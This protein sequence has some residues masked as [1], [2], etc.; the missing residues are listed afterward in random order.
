MNARYKYRFYPTDKQVNQ[1]AHQFGCTRYVYNWAL[2]MKSEAFREHG[3]KIGYAKTSK[4]LTSL[5]QE[6]DKTWLQDVSNVP[7]QQALRHLDKA[8]TAFFR[9][10]TKYPRFKRK[11]H[12]QSAT[13]T[14]NAFS[15]KD[16]DVEGQPFVSLAKQDGNL[17]IRWSRPL[18]SEPSSLTVIKEA[19]GRYFISFVV[20]IEPDT[21]PK[22][23]ASVGIDL[24]LSDIVV[25]S[26]GWQSGN[27]RCLRKTQN[28]LAKAQ[29]SLA[30]K[31][32]GSARWTKQRIKVARLHSKVSDQRRDF[33]HQLSTRLVRRYDVICTESLAVKNM[34]K[35]HCLA[36][37]ISDAGWGELVR[38]LEYK[39]EWYGKSVVKID[40][41]F[42][43]S[44]TCS[45]CGHVIESLPLNIRSW[46]CSSCMLEHHRDVNAA[47]N[48]L[49]EGHS[50]IA[51]GGER[52]P[53]LASVS[54]ALPD[55]V[56]IPKV[57]QWE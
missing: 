13:Y 51:H 40:R 23:N 4:R 55:E 48:I 52:R 5:K 44:K 12:R 22:T 28:D 11:R 49:A 2:G 38:M 46:K 50:V 27:P 54:G 47:K 8:Y 30:R 15:T 35:N 36:R 32:K 14:R 10:D 43:S 18:P 42:P 41:F 29:R 16:S 39:A 56:R 3:E 33:L 20:E 31:E 6:E 25:T 37:S 57:N 1:L 34:V 24:G 45:N 26:D 17:D 53:A 7:L 9:G 21:L 19:D